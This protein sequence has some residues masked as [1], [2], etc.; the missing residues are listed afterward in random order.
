MSADL[1]PLPVTPCGPCGPVLPCTPWGPW[2]PVS[3]C[4][5]VAPFINV[6]LYFDGSVESSGEKS[7]YCPINSLFA[8]SLILKPVLP[9]ELFAYAMCK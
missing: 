5:P 8:L 9:S 1:I 3:P 7:V 4:G 6:H 2:G